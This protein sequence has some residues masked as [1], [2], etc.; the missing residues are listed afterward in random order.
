MKK[1]EDIVEQ[2]QPVQH[3]P[4]LI[5]RLAGKLGI[6]TNARTVYG[7]P[8]INNGVTVIP[9]AKI[10]YGLGGG[11]GGSKEGSGE[12][13][14]AGV[15]ATPMGYIEIKDG[16]TSFRR[17][18]DPLALAPLI[19]AGGVAGT[20]ILRGIYRIMKQNGDAS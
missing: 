3:G 5:E 2:E 19:I 1:H 18:F 4:A 11:S 13:A 8:V 17:I 14:G 16:E 9:V 12:G 7:D 20:M 6:N 10:A 15:S